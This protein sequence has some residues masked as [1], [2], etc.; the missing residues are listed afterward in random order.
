MKPL[1]SLMTLS[2]GL[3]VFVACGGDAASESVPTAMVAPAQEPTA[4]PT[5]TP[6]LEPSATSDEAAASMVPRALLVEGPR[7]PQVRIPYSFPALQELLASGDPVPEE[8][9]M[10]REHLELLVEQLDTIR[11]A[12]ERY[13]DMNVA[14]ADGYEQVGDVAPN[15]GAHFVHEG[16][17]D[18]GVF[19][20][21]EPEII[22]Y[23]RDEAGDWRLRGT[24]FVFPREIVGDEHPEGF[25]GPLD[26]WHV[27]YELCTIPEQGFRTLPKDECE[28]AGGS[29][30]PSYGWMIHAWVHDDNP[31]GVFSMW[32]PNIPPLVPKESIRGFREAASIPFGQGPAE[33]HESRSRVVTIENFEH[34][35]VEIEVGEAIT[36]VNA[37]GVPH[38]VTAGLSGVGDGRFDSDLLGPGQAFTQHFDQEGSFPFTCLLH[39]Q[40]NG[41]VV[42]DRSGI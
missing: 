1:L 27:H 29:F 26:N 16:R 2:T 41:T 24:S 42:V 40:M 5:L 33:G 3:L 15:M 13:R 21:E 31:L 30:T 19:S 35:T 7:G 8:L 17:V 23:D 36:W 18:D 28:E 4:T 9:Q 20:V 22:L 39:P 14:L 12:T 10:S 32:N 11:S 6:R 34:S 25:A 37:D 38:T